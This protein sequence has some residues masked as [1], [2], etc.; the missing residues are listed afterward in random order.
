MRLT[1]AQKIG[2][3]DMKKILRITTILGLLPV[4]IFASEKQVNCDDLARHIKSEV[5]Q[6][7]HGGIRFFGAYYCRNELRSS[8][9]T[10]AEYRTSGCKEAGRDRDSSAIKILP[11]RITLF[12]RYQNALKR[13]VG[14][15]E[16]SSSLAS[17][18]IKDLQE[19]LDMSSQCIALYNEGVAE[20]LKE[21]Q[22][23]TAKREALETYIR[24]S[25]KK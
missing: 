2:R 10:A 5:A 6:L 16:I 4:V 7:E 11:G 13:C 22:E 17:Q 8:F 23:K 14:A 1:K 18:T 12:Q 25:N 9:W 19:K 20:V 3:I 24:D 15:S 21:K